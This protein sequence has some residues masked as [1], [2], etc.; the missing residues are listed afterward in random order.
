M[1]KILKKMQFGDGEAAKTRK[2]P[3]KDAICQPVSS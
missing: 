2:N 1:G 3:E